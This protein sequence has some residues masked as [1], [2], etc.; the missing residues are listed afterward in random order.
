MTIVIIY[1]NPMQQKISKSQ[2]KPQV[3][4]YLRKVEEYKKPLIITHL[5]KPVIK[6]IPY[7]ENVKDKLQA[8][9]KTVVFFNKPTYPVGENNWEVLK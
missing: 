5:G 4:E 1:F 2:F 7:S 9:R 3:L 8:L 6:I